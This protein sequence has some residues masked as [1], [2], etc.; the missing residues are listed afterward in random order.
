MR[1]LLRRSRVL[2]VGLV[3]VLAL[4]TALVI[5]RA[6]TA[7]QSAP[8]GDTRPVAA[9]IGDSDTRGAGATSTPLRWTSLVAK[10]EGW[11]ELNFGRSSTGYDTSSSGKV[12][13][14]QICPPYADLVD[15]VAAIDP[16]VLV[17]GG[18][19]S[20]W[21]A[22]RN[23]PDGTADVIDSLLTTVKQR[24]P[25][26]EIVVVGP[27]QPP[28]ARQEATVEDIDAHIRRAARARGFTFVDLL[29]PN[30]LSKGADVAA[31]RFDPDDSGHRAIADRVV[32]AL[33]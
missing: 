31:D 9:F 26:A 33:S 3:V 24:M 30:V 18:G 1:R 10:A 6:A 22:W 19:Q 7:R 16:D 21:R 5:G 20:D 17:I 14:Q 12:C 23:D 28:G 4:F 11:R 25:K 32:E 27:V 15:Q 13:G 29:E 2:Q 8:A